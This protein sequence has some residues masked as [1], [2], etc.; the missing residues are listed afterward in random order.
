MF[1]D[2]VPENQPAYNQVSPP[3]IFRVLTAAIVHADDEGDARTVDLLLAGKMA[4]VRRH[5][6][7]LAEGR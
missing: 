6:V 2:S 5:H 4:V 7:L 1:R 3:H